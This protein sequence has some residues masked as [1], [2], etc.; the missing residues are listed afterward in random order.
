MG[1]T[2][3]SQNTGLE[4]VQ[5]HSS[6]SACNLLSTNIESDGEKPLKRGWVPWDHFQPK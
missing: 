2:G 4:G 6:V 1:A 5:D 3:T